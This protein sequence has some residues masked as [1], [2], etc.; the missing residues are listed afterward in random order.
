MTRIQ[1]K[2]AAELD[3]GVRNRFEERARAEGLLDI[4]IATM[5]SPVGTLLLAATKRGL[6][7]FAFTGD[8]VAAALEELA[9]K[10]SRRILE[11]PPRL[12][13]VRRQLDEYFTGHRVDFELPLDRTLMGPLAR[14]VLGRTERIPYGSVS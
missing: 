1:V 6:V 11:S 7:G 5:D 8:G 12:E 10:L 14:R 2:R 13:A 4:A 3:E 9:G